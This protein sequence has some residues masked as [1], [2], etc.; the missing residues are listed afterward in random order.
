[1]TTRG[2][3]TLSPPHP[4]GTAHVKM[5]TRVIIGIPKHVI[6]TGHHWVPSGSFLSSQSWWVRRLAWNKR[7]EEP[8][9]VL[10]PTPGTPLHCCSFCLGRTWGILHPIYLKPH[11]L[12]NL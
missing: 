6:V 4:T 1:M 12:P 8:T 10:R 5:T 9:A 2:L 7:P 11:L 3:W